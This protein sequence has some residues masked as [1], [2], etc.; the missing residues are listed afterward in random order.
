[1]IVV[2]EILDNV[3]SQLPQMDGYKPIF[4]WG[5]YEHL[6]SLMKLYSSNSKSIY[7]LIYKTSV[8]S[9]QLVEQYAEIDLILVLAIQNTETSLIN[10]ERWAMS[11]KNTLYPL[12][13]NIEKC[14]EQVPVFIWDRKYKIKEYPNYG[15]DGKNK[16]T[17]IWDAIEFTTKIKI[18]HQNKDCDIQTINF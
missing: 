10:R 13:D 11:Y 16:A 15:N 6:N 18:T 8:G 14:F 12:V 5:N 9:S 2:E 4:D 17:D 3:F 7:P 1:M